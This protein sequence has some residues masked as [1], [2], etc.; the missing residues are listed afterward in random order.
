LAVRFIEIFG[1]IAG[2]LNVLALIFA[3][4]N[5]VGLIKENVGSHED[6]I[7]EKAHVDGFLGRALGELI[8]EGVHAFHLA[9]RD[10]ISQNDS[11]LGMGGDVGLAEKNAFFWIE[12]ESKIVENNTDNVFF[13]FFF[14]LDGGEAVKISDEIVNFVALVLKVNLRFDGTKEVADV[15]TLPTRG[16]ARKN[17]E[18]FIS[19]EDILA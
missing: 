10:V 3:D 11:E 2:K 5:G 13:E 6:G 15:E 7:I 14:I 4:G 19:H 17:A 1:N 16:D 9:V 18:L 8:F 12:A